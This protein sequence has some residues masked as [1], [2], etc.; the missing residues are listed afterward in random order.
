MST[1][2]TIIKKKKIKL[3][4]FAMTPIS[5]LPSL[6][7]IG[8]WAMRHRLMP[9]ILQSV[10]PCK[11]G[12]LIPSHTRNIGVR[13]LLWRCITRCT[14]K[15]KEFEDVRKLSATVMHEHFYGLKGDRKTMI[16]KKCTLTRPGL[17]LR[18]YYFLT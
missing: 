15:K 6:Q 10:R 2:I 9:V 12:K 8:K 3:F 18:D 1:A 14:R 17:G 7:Q 11:F 16:F 5:L 13:E 4:K